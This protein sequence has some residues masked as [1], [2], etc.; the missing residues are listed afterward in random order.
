M[1]AAPD[2]T[3]LHV[4]DLRPRQDTPVA[5]LLEMGHDQP[6]PVECQVIDTAPALKD[7]AAPRLSG[8]K[9][10]MDLRIVPQRL[11]VADSLRRFCDSLLI[12]DPGRAEIHLHAK[13]F[14]D[15]PLQD[16]PLDPAHD[17]DSDLFFLLVIGEVKH[18]ILLL[19]S[20]QHPVGAIEVLTGRKDEAAL[21]DGLQELFRLRRLCLRPQALPCA[22]GGQAG[23][24]DNDPRRS[25]LQGFK[26]YS[27]IEAQLGSLL[28]LPLLVDTFRNNLPG[29]KRSARHLQPGEPGT[30]PVVCDLVYPRPEAVPADRCRRQ[31][32]Q[33][34]QQ[35]IDPFFT[36]G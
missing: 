16:L 19:Q 18:R 34:S 12:N 8:L 9:E 20:P 10:E 36:Q 21:H 1:G 25:L 2:N 5:A 33:H 14:Q 24:R 32:V 29:Q 15:Q 17:L 27:F 30:V 13:P 22:G 6:L 11:E 31:S 23:H 26:F 3:D 7:Q 35:D 4:R 28:R